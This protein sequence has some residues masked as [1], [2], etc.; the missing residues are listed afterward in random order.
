MAEFINLGNSGF[1]RARNGEYVDK[2]A[3]IRYVNSTLRTERQFTCVCR[4][5]RFGKSMAA[6]MLCAYYDKSCDSKALFDGLNISLDASCGKYLNK[7]PVI[8]LDITDFTTTVGA[9]SDDMIK[10]MDQRICADLQS[11]YTS[12]KINEG[13]DLMSYLLQVVEHTG[14]QFIMII[15]EWDTICREAPKHQELM[16][17][18]V[19]WLRRLFKSAN[20]DRVFA[21]VYMTGILPI[22]QYNTQSALNNFEEY[23]MVSPG[24]LSQF[25][26][27]T[28][29]EVS[30]LSE[31]YHLD[32]D[33]VKRWY[34]GYKIGEMQSMYNPYS[35]MKAVGRG[36]YESFWTNTETYE[37]LRS[38][39][40]LNF[41]GLRD[42]VI[43][44]LSGGS[45]PVNVQLFSNN[46]QHIKSKDDALTTLIHLG[47]LSYDRTSQT[48]SIPNHEVHLEFENSIK[49]SNWGEVVDAINNSER[50]LQLTLSGNSDEV[51]K[52]IDT[53]HSDGSVSIIK[54]ND[55]NSLACI[56]SLAYYSA[57]KDYQIVREMPAGLGFADLAFVPRKNVSL[58]AL[59]VELKYNQSAETAISQIKQKRYTQSLQGYTGNVLLVGINYDKQT[60]KHSCV[61][62][63]IVL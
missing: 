54:Y 29:D 12:V 35:V 51:A 50:L 48:V 44:L 5:R 28:T 34:D 38:Y 45:V 52:A 11:V 56:L 47:Y 58:P 59:I 37:S 2:S 39:I 14:E 18:Y 22:K 23:T 43:V 15:D 6:K 3:L 24:P 20:T 32:I 57:R 13:S 63:S 8:Y 49:E 62:E 21:G 4:S 30:G 16:K 19:D 53:I 40:T 36:V 9:Y 27:F 7:F 42:D 33:E 25:F 1:A 61:I 41:E 31:K 10:R 60:K 55:E 46:I 26:G 17:Q